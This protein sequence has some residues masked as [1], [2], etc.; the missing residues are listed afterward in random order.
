MSEKGVVEFS[1]L[2]LDTD[3][4]P[5][6]TKGADYILN[7]VIMSDGRH[8]VAVN[9]KGNELVVSIPGMA[10]GGTVDFFGSCN[11]YAR[12]R[13]IFFARHTYNISYL[14]FDITDFIC[15]F[16]IE[17]ET[18]NKVLSV[19]AIHNSLI[20]ILQL[21]NFVNSCVIGDFLTW[22]TGTGDIKE[23]NYIRAYNHTNSIVTDYTYTSITSENIKLYK[24][25]SD[26]FSQNTGLKDSVQTYPY[27]I[28]QINRL[29]N[30][31]QSYPYG[32]I[33]KTY[34]FACRCI[35]LDNEKSTL[36]QISDIQF[37]SVKFYP[38][39]Q[40]TLEDGTISY[41]LTFNYFTDNVAKCEIFV[42]DNEQSNWYSYDVIKVPPSTF[43]GQTVS[44]TKNIWVSQDNYNSISI[45]ASIFGVDSAF[46]TTTGR[47]IAKTIDSSNNYTLT[48]NRPS[49][50][51]ASLVITITPQKSIIYN[52]DDTKLR[53][54]VDQTE[55]NRPYDYIPQD[56]QNITS[57]ED[58]R[59][60]SSNFTEG[61]D[62]VSIDCITYVVSTPKFNLFPTKHGK[63][64]QSGP[65]WYLIYP[66]FGNIYPSPPVP[67]YEI[68]FGFAIKSHDN[69]YYDDVSFRY[70]DITGYKTITDVYNYII[71]QLGAGI[72]TLSSYVYGGTSYPAL[73]IITT[74][75]SFAGHIIS[76]LPFWKT[77]LATTKIPDG[78]FDVYDLYIKYVIS[79]TFY[80]DLKSGDSYLGGAVYFD[81][82]M[83][84]G[85]V[86]KFESPILVNEYDST[87]KKNINVKIRNLP[88]SWAYY[89]C[90]A[91]T[92]R[93]KKGFN[94]QLSAKKNIDFFFGYDGFLRIKVQSIINKGNT[95]NNKS[96]ISNYEF[97]EG[98]KI[99]LL[100]WSVNTTLGDSN[101]PP[102]SQQGEFIRFSDTYVQDVPVLKTEYPQSD[103]AYVKDNSTGKDYI[104]DINGNKVFDV[105]SQLLIAGY[106]DK[107][108]SVSALDGRVI[109][110]KDVDY[111][112]FEIYREKKKID[113][114]IYY[115]DTLHKVGRDSSG[116]TYHIG[117][118][119]NQNPYAPTTT[120][121]ILTSNF[122]DTYVRVRDCKYIY[123]CQDD[124]FSDYYVSNFY[125]FGVANYFDENQKKSKFSNAIRFGGKLIQKTQVNDINKFISSDYLSLPIEYGDITN[126]VEVGT[127]LKVLHQNEET[128]IYVGRTEIQNTD[129]TSNI[130][131]SKSVLGTV[132][133]LG[134]GN[135][136]IY[137][138][139]IVVNKRDLYYLDVFTGEVIRSSPNGRYPISAYGMKTYFKN[140]CK[141][142][143]EA[144]TDKI[145]VIG[146]YDEENKVY[147][148][149]FCFNT[150]GI[151]PETLGF[152]DPKIEGITPRW[153]SFFSYTPKMYSS[154]GNYLLSF[155]GVNGWK[156]NS[157][158]V[159]RCNFYGTK[160]IQNVRWIFNAMPILKKLFRSVGIRSNIAWNVNSI[161]IEP[162][163]TYK[164]GMLSKL[165]PT[166]FTLKEG[167][168]WASYNKN[169]LTTSGIPSNIDLV[170][171]DALRGYYIKHEMTNN[172]DNETWLLN[173]Q[174]EYELSNRF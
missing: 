161:N 164:R 15:Y 160:Y 47:I 6:T 38:N 120:P 45:G 77:F 143:V 113:Q 136:T 80:K 60:L 86:N 141:Q 148:L 88:P 144:G 95:Y 174:V 112:Q 127:E 101:I 43:N 131:A 118:S 72:A 33:N 115:H 68:E 150:A 93:V 110:I 133:N 49:N 63:A 98:D 119:Q 116:N 100:G 123:T 168:F 53:M 64:F 103:D 129:G 83:K 29:T 104:L 138:R 27:S 132:N 5:K 21:D 10:S 55:V 12:N 84:Y 11:D 172:S 48:I 75:A 17:T 97:E 99:R 154:I 13:I 134:Y 66:E 67:G 81:K 155:I 25:T 44:G 169:M 82:N 57:V 37:S 9:C 158:S 171:G 153:V 105:S 30:G 16:D 51:S 146:T 125:G 92:P 142:I 14:N 145:D 163:A 139:T 62:P 79:D 91:F 124:N 149:T 122:G 126:V 166:K 39:G 19:N 20:T 22:T 96:I 152:Y 28:P 54:P 170:N 41:N 4:D 78:E 65:Y 40:Y 61:F 162:D 70:T 18:T 42:R 130:S 56:V 90:L 71:S 135:G 2:H 94:I 137:P 128:S 117:D 8:G 34:Q 140:K 3:S 74:S 73:K 109:H 107:T 159:A 7:T 102:F 69:L 111:L 151:L 156:H 147:L 108:V 165:D 36:S 58:N 35:Y 26:S 1:D 89:Y 46:N 23:I 32:L 85:S 52:F 114:A 173:T 50:Y 106:D 167:E 157:T 121:A 24:K 59:I 87:A 31:T 76:M